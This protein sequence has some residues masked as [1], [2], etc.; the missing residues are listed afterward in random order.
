MELKDITKET[1]QTYSYRKNKIVIVKFPEGH[2][3]T[4]L[5][6]D[7]KKPQVPGYPANG[8]TYFD[9]VEEAIKAIHDLYNSLDYTPK[10]ADEGH[11]YR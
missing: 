8:L 9:S 1:L 11:Y 7:I 10:Y 3:L 5:V 6:E 2:C 4:F